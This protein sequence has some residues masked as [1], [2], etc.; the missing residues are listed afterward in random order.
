MKILVIRQG[1]FGDMLIITPILRFLKSRGHEVHVLTSDRGRDILKNNTNVDKLHYIE[2]KER[3]DEELHKAWKEK[4]EEIKAEKVINF[5]ESI[6]VHIALH[7]RSPKYNWPKAERKAVANKNYYEET[8]NWSKLPLDEKAMYDCMESDFFNP[9]MFY[10]FEELSQAKNY[11][12]P[13]KF[14]ILVCLSGSGKNKAYPW[15]PAVMGEC[16]KE[17]E[18]VH[19]ITV[20]DEMCQLLEI[21]GEKVTNLS[22][23]I[24]IRVSMALTGLVDLVISPDTGVLHASGQYDTPKIGLLGHTTIENITKHFRNDYSIEADERSAECAPCFRLIYNVSIQC[25][26][27]PLSKAAYCMSH[28][29]DPKEVFNRIKEVYAK[30]GRKEV[31]KLSS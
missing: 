20:G 31:S 13:D 21:Q 7:P 25:P 23:K 18:D 29:I 15:M 5:T 2:A 27:D 26:Q 14:N 12:R 16:I 1:A 10:D 6:E 9:E 19:L 17:I 8:L 24:P 3:T 22:G 30:H 4:E 11:V 28:G